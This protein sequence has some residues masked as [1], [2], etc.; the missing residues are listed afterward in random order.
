MQGRSFMKSL[1]HGVLAEGTLFPFPET[2]PSERDNLGGMLDSVRKFFAATVDSK[3]LDRE[4]A[5]P[6]AVLRGLKELGLFGLLIPQEYGGI[7]VSATG[8]A[9]LIEEVA[10][11]DPSV[12]VT[13]GG[14][15]SIGLKAILLFGTAAQKTKY[16]PRLATGEHVAAFALTE[17]GAGSDAAAIQTRAEETTEGDYLLNGSKIWITNGGFADVFTVFARTRSS[18]D[19]AKRGITAFLV[20]RAW[21]VKSGPNEHKLGIRA[22]STTELFF[23][24]VRVPKEN[25]LGEVGRGYQVAMAVLNSGRL[26]LASGCIGSCKALIKLAIERCQER[27]AFGRRIGEFGLIKDKVATMVADCFAL[28]SMTYLTTGLVDAQVEDYSIESAICKIYGSE[29]LWQTVNASMQIAAG[30]GYMQEY[31]YERLLRDA[32]INLIFEGTNEVLRCFIALSG[33]QS[34]RESMDVSKGVSDVAIRGA[35]AALARTPLTRAHVA[36]GREAVILEQYAGELARHVDKLMRKQGGQV[37]EN[38]HAQRRI[39]DMA[40]DL[41]ALSACVSRTTRAI[42]RRGEAAARR[43]ID[44][45]GIVAAA[46]E[47]RM[48][49]IVASFDRNDD[50]LRKATAT[51]AYADGVYPFDVLRD[52][53]VQDEREPS[54]SRAP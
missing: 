26:G 19:G 2:S 9:R 49:Q 23:D 39:A 38:Q 44:L 52:T 45:T 29:T 18:E 43:E 6:D 53:I 28:E 54:H 3:Q 27:K 25:V 31:P 37:L 47:E 1:F 13:L 11:L 32:R 10:G 17:P 14:H 46:A 16:L 30:I 21:G 36:L 34:G 8:Y 12:A 20:E 51:R 40:I 5:I 41:F 4:A 42:E 48:R 24:D 35:R 15:Q 50:E 33:M 7:G 22:S